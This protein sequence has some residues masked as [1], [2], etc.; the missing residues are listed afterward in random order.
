MDLSHPQ[1]AALDALCPH[2]HEFQNAPP[3]KPSTAWLFHIDARNVVATHW[4]AI[5]RDDGQLSGVRVRLLETAGRAVSCGFH[6]H[7]QLT[8]A[9][10]LDF[11]GS[12][13]GELKV[14]GEKAIIDMAPG[15]WAQLE[16]EW[17]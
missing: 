7:R 16:V 15:E 3:P 12:S 8:A 6:S 11:S 13:L 10:R 2:F 14:E 9:R 4:E 17:L 1:T 5:P